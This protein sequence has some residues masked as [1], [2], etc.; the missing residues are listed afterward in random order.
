MTTR[1]GDLTKPRRDTSRRTGR[2]SRLSGFLRA[3]AANGRLP[4]FLLSVG[5]TVLL[6][7]FLFSRD[8]TVRTVVVRGNTLAYADAIVAA[9]GAIGQPIFRLNTDVVARRVAAYPAVAYADVSAQLP[10]RLVVQ[11][12][13]RTPV[14]DWQVG[15]QSVLV[16]DH[17][18]VVATG[19][20]AK[21]PRVVENT[22]TLPVVG[23]QLPSGLIAADQAI[24]SRLGAQVSA[25]EYDPVS[26]LT[27]QLTDGREIVFGGSDRIPLKLNVAV[28][29]LALSDPWT[30]LDVREPDRPYYQ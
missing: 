25:M 15:K 11:L 9:S 21:L 23:S 16:D 18:W 14:L 4:A 6:F 7:G 5:L 30:R 13:E 3:S 27:A 2:N 10:D 20:D 17:G 8:F 28:A 29:A 1:T 12:H 19:F 24:L 26:G 22:G